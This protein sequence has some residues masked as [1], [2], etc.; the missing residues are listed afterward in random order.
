MGRAI[1]KLASDPH[2]SL[3]PETTAD[4]QTEVNQGCVSR[5]QV[6]RKYIKTSNIVV[7][8]D[9]VRNLYEFDKS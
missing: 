5:S 1:R 2:T 4:S 7:I 8:V 3:L 9:L 6:K